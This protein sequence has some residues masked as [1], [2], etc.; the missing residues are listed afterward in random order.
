MKM[1]GEPCGVSTKKSIAPIWTNAK[2]FFSSC[3]RDFDLYFSLF[4]ITGA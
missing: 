2:K 1:A 3:P 4:I